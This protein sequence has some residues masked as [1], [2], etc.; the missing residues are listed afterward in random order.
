MQKDVCFVI[1]I[2]SV[3]KHDRDGR[4]RRA[5]TNMHETARSKGLSGKA[6][7]LERFDVDFLILFR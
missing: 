2:D 1:P 3:M 4:E 5:D 6:E 7:L